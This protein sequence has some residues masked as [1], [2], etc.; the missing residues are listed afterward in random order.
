MCSPAYSNVYDHALGMSPV[1]RT[2]EKPTHFRCPV[3]DCRQWF[4]IGDFHYSE[5]T[6]PKEGENLN[7]AG[8]IRT[9]LV[10]L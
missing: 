5:P 6:W 2:D 4:T 3:A 1:E 8:R 9:N 7:Q 10:K